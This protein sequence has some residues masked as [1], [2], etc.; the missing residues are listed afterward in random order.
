M[1][2]QDGESSLF[3]INPNIYNNLSNCWV[4]H[5]GKESYPDN[6]GNLKN[7]SSLEEVANGIG[8]NYK[9]LFND[10]GNLCFSFSNY[11]LWDNNVS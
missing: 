11:G 6:Y 4:L 8:E 5:E 10:H 3:L 9:G 7:H 1:T 2:D